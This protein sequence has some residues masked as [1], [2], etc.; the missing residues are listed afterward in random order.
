M[1]DDNAAPND[2]LART[3]AILEAVLVPMDEML[4]GE[5]ED[6][7]S[8]VLVSLLG[9]ALMRLIAGGANM[10]A[11]NQEMEAVQEKAFALREAL[12]DVQGN[13]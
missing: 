6:I 3:L 9:T 7:Y 1:T 5:D 4:K 12:S 8:R 11:V 10:E 2:P 13:A